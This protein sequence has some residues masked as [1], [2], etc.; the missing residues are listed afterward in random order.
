MFIDGVRVETAGLPVATSNARRN[1]LFWRY[2]LPKGK[3][4]VTFK[5]LNSREDASVNFT[6]ALIYSDSLEMNK[7]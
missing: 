3:H 7:R 4:V 5:W 1:D 2:Q 6:D